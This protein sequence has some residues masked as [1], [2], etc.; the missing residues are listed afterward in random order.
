MLSTYSTPCVCISL[1]WR[2]YKGDCALTAKPILLQYHMEPWYLWKL[3]VTIFIQYMELRFLIFKMVS[4]DTECFLNSEMLPF[5]PVQRFTYTGGMVKSNGQCLHERFPLCT[6]HISM[7]HITLLILE[8]ILSEIYPGIWL[9]VHSL[10]SGSA[11]MQMFM[12]EER[13]HTHNK[14][15]FS[16]SYYISNFSNSGDFIFQ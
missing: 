7:A 1:V 11:L 8:K 14:N 6:T 4:Y 9:P 15:N 13:V 12:F 10:Q 16:V 5:I 2:G 3:K